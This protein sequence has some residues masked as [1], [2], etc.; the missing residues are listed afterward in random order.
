MMPVIKK[1]GKVQIYVDLKRLNEAVKWERFILPSLEDI[2]PKLVGE[3]VFPC[4]KRPVDSGK[5]HWNLA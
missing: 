5:F 2:A 1:I 4:W 3:R